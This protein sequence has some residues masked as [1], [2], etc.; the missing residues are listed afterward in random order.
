MLKFLKVAEDSLAP[1]FQ[2]GDFVL[3]SKIPFLFVPSIPWGCNRFPPAR[4]WVTDQAHP[5]HQLGQRGK[6]HWQS[7]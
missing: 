6:C 3:V 5:K 4:L 7:P 1:E 2:S